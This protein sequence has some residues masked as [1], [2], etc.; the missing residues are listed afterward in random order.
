MASKRQSGSELEEN[1][2]RLL[3]ERS[4]GNV[5]IE[6]KEGADDADLVEDE[7]FDAEA[8][9]K[10]DLLKQYRDLEGQLKETREQMLR[11]VADA[12]NF[13]KRIER[14]KEGQTRYANERIIRELLPVMDNLERALSHSASA[15]DDVAGLLDGLN[16]TLKG[17]KDTLA[18]F[19][20]T[21]VEAMGKPFDPNFHEAVSQE[22]RSTEESNTVVRELQKG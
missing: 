20:C 10:A 9:D 11:A 21:P 15:A 19:G 18:R 5:D 7:P 17:F 22:E 8:A 1:A 4:A 16:M 13:K 14:E 2:E 12:D 3:D 6:E